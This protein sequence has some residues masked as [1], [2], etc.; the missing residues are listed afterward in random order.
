[1]RGLLNGSKA[2]SLFKKGLLFRTGDRGAIEDGGCGWV[3]GWWGGVGGVFAC[4][5]WLW[6]GGE[7][8]VVVLRCVLCW[9]VVVFVCVCVCVCVCLCVCVCVCVSVCVCV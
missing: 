4:G 1:M 2:E 3:W 6:V 8:C 5:W 9:V 7:C